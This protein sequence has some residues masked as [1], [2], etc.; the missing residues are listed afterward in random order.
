MRGVS[1]G[2]MCLCFCSD[3]WSV[4]E[5]PMPGLTPSEAFLKERRPEWRKRKDRAQLLAYDIQRNIQRRS[6]MCERSDGDALYAQLGVTTN[7]FK[8]DPAR[9]LKQCLTPRLRAGRDAFFHH[10]GLH[11]VEEDVA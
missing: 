2:P 6:R 10:F 4:H 9:H 1:C 11:V 8:I 7:I 5:S 3:S